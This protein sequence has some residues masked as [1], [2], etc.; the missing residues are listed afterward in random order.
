MHDEDAIITFWWLS[1][2]QLVK[3]FPGISFPADN[4]KYTWILKKY[5]FLHEENFYSYPFYS[6]SRSLSD[7]IWWD[8]KMISLSSV[9][10]AAELQPR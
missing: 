7:L 6:L 9:I 10:S 4:Q 5:I 1:C 8:L 2:L 3:L